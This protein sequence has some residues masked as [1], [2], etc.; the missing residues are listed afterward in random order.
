MEGLAA[1]YVHIDE[2]LK[3][4]LAASAEELDTSQKV[5]VEEAITL[6]LAS[7]ADERRAAREA[8]LSLDGEVPLAEAS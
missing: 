8:Q 5:L 7:I 6:L 3:A 4:E 1:L 2:S